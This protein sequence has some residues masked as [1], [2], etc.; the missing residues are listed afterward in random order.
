MDIF[1]HCFCRASLFIR[2]ATLIMLCT[3]RVYKSKTLWLASY[4]SLVESESCAPLIPL[5]GE[6]IDSKVIS[7]SF[8]FYCRIIVFC[9]QSLHARGQTLSPA[10]IKRQIDIFSLKYRYFNISLR[11]HY[12]HVL[13]FLVFRQARIPPLPYVHDLLFISNLS[14]SW[15]LWKSNAK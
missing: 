15:C 12:Y 2:A 11:G 5:L 4:V 7:T 13:F 10:F 3:S 1:D 8:F 14:L 6:L 9:N